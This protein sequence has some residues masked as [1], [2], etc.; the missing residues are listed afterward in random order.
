[1]T[2][3]PTFDELREFLTETESDWTDELLGLDEQ[4][5]TSLLLGLVQA[6][7]G[8]R[9]RV[10]RSKRNEGVL[11]F[12]AEESPE[13]GVLHVLH[14]PKGNWRGQTPRL[15]KFFEE[16]RASPVPTIVV[17]AGPVG[18]YEALLGLTRLK[19]VFVVA[20]AQAAGAVRRT[21]LDGGYTSPTPTTPPPIQMRML[22]D[23]PV[24]DVSEDLLDFN[25]YAQALAGLVDN[26]ETETPF[27]FAINAPWGAGKSSL[28][29]L[30]DQRLTEKPAAAG[31]APHVTLWFNAWLHDDAKDVGSALTAEIARAADKLRPWWQRWFTSPVSTAL[32]A[33]RARFWR[34]VFV[35]GLVGFVSLI[36]AVVALNAAPDWLLD[37]LVDDYEKFARTSLGGLV[38][39]IGSVALTLGRMAFES[40]TAVANFVADPADQAGQGSLSEV[41]SQLE[42][43]VRQA[44]PP[45]SRFVVFVDDLER[46]RPPGSVDLL[47]SV[48]QLLSF[49]PVVVVVM[50]D[51]NALAVAVEVKYEA[52]AKRYAPTN[53]QAPSGASFGDQFLQKMVQLQFDLPDQPKR[54]VLRLVKEVV[55]SNE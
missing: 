47:E 43:L 33:P 40:T 44:T 52:L 45:G 46:C 38:F 2:A 9:V 42:R 54:G 17:L 49:D 37:M 28:A 6:Q 15:A 51:V 13:E 3:R 25:A 21:I 7:F 26:P 22:S 30:V 32:L 36:L 27:T 31:T 23:R 19:D 48:N 53:G 18:D 41:R 20:P 4:G 14:V 29:R 12:P 5:V 11:R 34:R 35:G 24:T 1:M 8:E 55:G 39:L 16:A 50:A 10:E